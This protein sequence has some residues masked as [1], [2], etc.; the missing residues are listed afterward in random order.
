M[1]IKAHLAHS[2]T[3]HA[4][5]ILSFE[6]MEVWDGW[7][8]NLFPRRKIKVLTIIHILLGNSNYE[9]WRH[10]YKRREKRWDKISVKIKL[11]EALCSLQNM[12]KRLMRHNTAQLKCL[13]KVWGRW[14]IKLTHTHKIS[15]G[16]V[17]TRFH[18]IIILTSVKM[19]SNIF[20]LN[21]WYDLILLRK[22]SK[23]CDTL[24]VTF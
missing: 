1:D 20:K 3:L 2:Y 13:S 22:I 11:L 6:G 8:L 7:D 24:K 5:N 17:H 18:T 15:Q 19:S 9:F 21:F 4:T 23:V 10:F 14:E 12:C 16:G